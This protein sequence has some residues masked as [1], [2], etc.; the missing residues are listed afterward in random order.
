MQ[1]PQHIYSQVICGFN[2]QMTKDALK[3]Q[4]QLHL[5]SELRRLI[6]ESY[7]DNA[8][9][10][11]RATG[12]DPS[13]IS[14]MLYPLEKNGSKAIEQ[15]IIDQI[16]VVH[17]RWPN[18]SSALRPL[19]QRIAPAGFDAY[20]S[21]DATVEYQYPVIGSVRAG[22]WHD[23]R[24]NYAPGDGERFIAHSYKGGRAFF[25]KVEGDSMEPTFEEGDLVLV[26]TDKASMPGDLVVAKDTDTQQATFKKLTYEGGRYFLKPENRQ[27]QAIEIDDP[28]QRLIGRVVRHIRKEREL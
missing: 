5:K 20:L 21:G 17:A 25:L 11:S 28:A 13:Y 9:A 26:D 23:I 16:Q 12:I 15:G 22:I 3:H 7:D 14:R 19:T 18:G 1:Y 2:A 10:F 4:R 24:D 27:Y 6:V 8:A